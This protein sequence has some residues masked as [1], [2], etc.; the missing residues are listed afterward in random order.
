ME[1]DYFEKIVRKT[2]NGNGILRFSANNKLKIYSDFR[3]F[4]FSFF[5]ER[6]EEREKKRER[7][8]SK[9]ERNIDRLPSHTH[10]NW[11]S[12]SGLSGNRTCNLGICPDWKLNQ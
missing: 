3:T 4:C 7:E 1:K 2:T 10:P 6:D 9:C 12:N 5:L 11:G 8:T